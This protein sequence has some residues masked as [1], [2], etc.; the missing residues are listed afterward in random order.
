MEKKSINVYNLLI[1]DESGSMHSIYD[2]ALSGINETLNGIR[3]AQRDYPDQN[4]YVSIVTFEGDG[5]AGVK[6]R[7]DSVPASKVEH[8]EDH[9]NCRKP[10]HEYEES[11]KA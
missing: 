6:T 3:N 2:Q 1:I 9:Y 10:R 4:Q 11:V 8:C 5:V 7:R